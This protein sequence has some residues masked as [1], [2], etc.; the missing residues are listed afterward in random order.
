MSAGW[1]NCDLLARSITI[2]DSVLESDEI[3]EGYH[4]VNR[5]RMVYLKRIRKMEYYDL[6]FL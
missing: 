1:Q 6:M 3:L 5:L 4:F 2:I